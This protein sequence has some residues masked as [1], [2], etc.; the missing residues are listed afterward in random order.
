MSVPTRIDGY[1]PI[2]DYAAIGDGRTAALVARDGSIDWLCLPDLDSGSVVRRAA[3][4]EPGR[5]D[6]SSHRSSRSRPTRRYVPGTNVLETTFTTAGGQ[7]ARHRRD[8]AR[9]SAGSRRTAS[10][11]ATSRGCPAGSRCAGASSH[12]STTASGTRHSAARAGVPVAERARR[13]RGP[14]LGRRRA[15]AARR[16]RS[17]AVRRAGAVARRCSSLAAAHQ[18][19]LVFSPRAEVERR[20]ERDAST[21]GAAG[22][23][24]R[25]T[26]GRGA[27]RSC[28]ARWR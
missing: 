13:G 15:A 26:T 2:R 9:R 20:L 7:R 17:R 8:D 1:A 4:R 14:R 28:A 16:T 24:A 18:E 3:R 25:R 27:R 10:S 23:G 12:A 22:R 6:S 21:T 11:S 19:P 5:G